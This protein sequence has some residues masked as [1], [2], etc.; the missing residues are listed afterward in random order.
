MGGEQGQ[1]GPGSGLM[2]GGA[3]DRA[4]GM[5]VVNRE[6]V[7]SGPL[8]RVWQIVRFV[9]ASICSVWMLLLLVG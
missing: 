1:G 8:A 5:G 7:V 3:D 9:S 2:D 6:W 4:R